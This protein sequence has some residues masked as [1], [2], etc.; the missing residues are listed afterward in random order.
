MKRLCGPLSIFFLIFVFPYLAAQEGGLDWDIDTI[1]DEPLPETPV[2]QPENTTEVSALNL[3]RQRGFTFDANYEFI[4][5]LAPGWDVYPWVSAD[6]EHFSWGQALK[7]NASL[8]LTAQIS[9]VFRVRNTIGFSIPDF[10]FNLGDLFFDYNMYDRIFFR[11]GKYSLAWGISPNFGFTNLLARVPG[12]SYSGDSYIFKADV[13][14]GVGGVQLLTMTRAN[15]MG[16][17]VPARKDFGFGGKYNLAFHW[18]DFDMG[19]FYQEGMAL[20]GFL[21]IKTT[22]GNTE[23]YNEWLTAVDI[24][25]KYN[26][27]GAGNLGFARDFFNNKLSVNGELF[28]NAEGESYWY[29]PESSYRDA[30]TSPFIEGFN[31]ALNLLYR[32]G[33]RGEP[34]LFLQTLYAPMQES[35]RLVP[36]FRLRPW[37]HIELYLA[38]PVALGN[39]NGYYYSYTADP[40]NRPFS[41]VMLIT[42]SGS[43]QAGYHY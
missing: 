5:G 30:E 34:R 15:L 23:F 16:G 25:D 41:V 6:D 40:D 32:P 26:T 9:E 35:I 8:G 29:R 24:D 37:Q 22:I 19:A 39:K 2:E 4:A 21:S 3:V 12:N 38:V 18:A 7:V 27:S 36:G 28:F 13:P 42:L 31:M 43:V 17:D 33:G 10:G 14:V 1:F 11:G 20:R